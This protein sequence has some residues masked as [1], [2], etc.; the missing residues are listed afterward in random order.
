MTTF[1]WTGP[2]ERDPELVAQRRAI[3]GGELGW[4]GDDHDDVSWDRYDA[5]S[6]ALLVHDGG[7]LVASGRLTV[8]RDGPSELGDLV[9]W[10]AALPVELR[11]APAAEWSRV[12]IAP[13]FRRG[14]LFRRMYEAVRARA[15]DRGAVLLS[16]A[17]VAELRPLYEAL[18]FTYVDVPFR[19]SFFARS[20][21]YYPAYQRVSP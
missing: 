9:D 17:S 15:R 2:G 1:R 16:G 8:E 13:A 5:Y 4:L 21:I 20:P 10:R 19:S 6:T 14:G 3:Y 18:G 11:A 12:M 7:A